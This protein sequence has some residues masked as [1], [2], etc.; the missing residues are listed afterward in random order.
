MQVR[1]GWNLRSTS[2][3]EI[4]SKVCCVD[5][6]CT[7]ADTVQE[8][9]LDT[10]RLLHT[11]AENGI[12]LNPSKFQF[13]QDTIDFAG[14]QV[15][16]TSLMPSEKM[17]ESIRKFPTPKNISGVRAYFGLVNQVAYAFAMTEEMQPFRHLLSPKVR[18]EW[19]Q[20]LDTLFRKSKEVII[21]RVSEGIRLFDPNLTT[22]LATDFS[23]K[24][25]GFLLLQKTCSCDSKVPTCCPEGWR[26]C[27]VGSRF[28]HDAENRYAPIEGECL[29]V[30]YGLQKC[31]Y[32]LLGC[33]DLV[34]A[35]DHKPLVN[36]LNDRYLGDI[37]NGRLR[38]MKEKTLAFNFIIKHVPGRKHLGPDAASRY[39]VSEAM[40]LDL[41]GESSADSE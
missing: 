19:S 33:R 26:V 39:P 35:T 11:C 40:D 37:E 10:C 8:S 18:F 17:L 38:N 20:E 23:G 13:C 2:R 36:I 12:T 7:W 34:I 16:P 41:S 3:S 14:F 9:F 29:A 27:L 1:C 28:L 6:T 25:V 21:D 32:F 24:G 30:V 22:C 15:S 5:D 4:G 31:K